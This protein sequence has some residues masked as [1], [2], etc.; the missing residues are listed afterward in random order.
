MEASRTPTAD[1]EAPPRNWDR[2]RNGKGSRRC[3][4][5]KLSWEP[6]FSCPLW[7]R[8]ERFGDIRQAHETRW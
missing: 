3:S 6:S 7:M 8:D 2:A 5:D 1:G 4:L